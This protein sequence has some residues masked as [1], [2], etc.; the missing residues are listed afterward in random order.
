MKLEIALDVHDRNDARAIRTVKKLGSSPCSL[1]PQLGMRAATRSGDVEYAVEQTEA[2]LDHLPEKPHTIYSDTRDSIC[3]GIAMAYLAGRDEDAHRLVRKLFA[4][5]KNY[6]REILGSQVLRLLGH[7]RFVDHILPPMEELLESD[8]DPALAEACLHLLAFAPCLTPEKWDRQWEQLGPRPK[9]RSSG[10]K[11]LRRLAVSVHLRFDR[12]EQAARWVDK[13]HGPISREQKQPTMDVIKFLRSSEARSKLDGPW[14]QLRGSIMLFADKRHKCRWLLRWDGRCFRLSDDGPLDEPTGLD[15]HMAFRVVCK[16]GIHTK[17]GLTRLNRRFQHYVFDDENDVWV[18]TW[19][20]QGEDHAY[21]VH[22]GGGTEVPFLRHYLK[23]GQPGPGRYLLTWTLCKPYVCF[24]AGNDYTYLSR[25]G[26]KG[27]IFLNQKIG[28]LAGANRPAR[29][30]TTIKLH[31]H[32]HI[33]VY[34]DLGL[35]SVNEKGNIQ[36]VELG[37]RDPNQWIVLS[38]YPQAEGKVYAGCLPQNGGALFEIDKKTLKVRRT[39]GYCGLGPRGAFAY[40][41]VYHYRV[42]RM[43]EGCIVARGNRP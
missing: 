23:H 38:T 2:L 15:R 14:K 11:K 25:F 35:W 4:L 9:D 21:H 34:S 42:S 31:K 6:R 43:H 36:R 8:P 13:K 19:L 26:G 29:I 12:V 18:K 3:C 20:L 28:Q 16:E 30:S 22:M 39:N 5:S 10:A 17:G 24:Q 27:N 1:F 32:P 33:L 7:A 37:L 41:Y 40:E